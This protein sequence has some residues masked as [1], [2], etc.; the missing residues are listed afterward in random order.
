M[1]SEDKTEEIINKLVELEYFEYTDPQKLIVAKE[2]IRESLREGYLS[3][4]EE[5]ENGEYSSID[6]RSYLA[7]QESLAEGSVGETMKR[8]LPILEKENITI[9]FIKDET[10]GTNYSLILNQKK[11]TIFT[12]VQSQIDS[13]IIA[14][15]RLI[16][17]VNEFLE[18]AGS[19]ERL[20]GQSGGNDGLVIFLT[21]RLFNYI[22]SLDLIKN[23]PFP[24]EELNS[25]LS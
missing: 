1:Y 10:D 19:A 22:K 14:H 24:V 15:K 20:Y 4:F 12:Q 8:M 16:E 13:W 3:S 5:D 21:E 11:Y 6:R 7:D 23:L 2:K 17:I 18:N 25:Q 9:S